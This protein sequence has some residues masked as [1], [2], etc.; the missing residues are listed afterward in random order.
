MKSLTLT[1]LLFLC[2]SSLMGGE[3]LFWSIVCHPCEE[4]QKKYYCRITYYHPYQ[5]RWGSRVA[6]PKTTRAEQG[7]TVAAHPNFKFGTQV[8]IP[9]LAGKVGDGRFVVQDRGAWVTKKKASRGKN[10]VFDVYISTK[11]SYYKMMKN[12]PYMWVYASK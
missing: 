8:Y 4:V 11:S 1:G 9:D 5:D 12:S 10:Y 2:F 7:I 3:I 6:C